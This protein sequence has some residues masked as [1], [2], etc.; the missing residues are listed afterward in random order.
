MS[1][2]LP[3][4]RSDAEDTG[5]RRCAADSLRRIDAIHVN[6]TKRPATAVAVGVAYRRSVTVP[7]TL[8]SA[9]RYAVLGVPT[10]VHG[11]SPFQ[12]A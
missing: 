11:D 6:V 10:T 4:L 9:A 8:V 7:I 5:M 1:L 3:T 2:G 12:V